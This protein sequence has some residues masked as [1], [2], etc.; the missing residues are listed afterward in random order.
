MCDLCKLCGAKVTIVGVWC[1]P[2]D[3]IRMF[4]F[5]FQLTRVHF[6]LPKGEEGPI[7]IFPMSH[8]VSATKITHKPP[9]GF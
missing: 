8:C 4:S 2:L 7:M 5:L 9:N 3:Y 1:E 6:P